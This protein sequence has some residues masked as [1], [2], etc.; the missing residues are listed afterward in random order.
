V[1]TLKDSV[2]I[3]T[4]PEELFDWFKNL[5]KHFE[6]WHPNHKKFVKV[7]GGTDEG[8]IVYSEELVEG[9]WYKVKV[10]I[11]K[12]EKS[13][14]G[15]RIELLKG[16]ALALPAASTVVITVTGIGSSFLNISGLS[17]I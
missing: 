1:I 10:K 2:E 15:W 4:T 7:T 11:G 3:K 14:Q 17:S 13:E 16:A 6:E 12:L 9:K 8:D 5:D